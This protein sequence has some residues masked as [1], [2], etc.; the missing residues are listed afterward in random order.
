[1]LIFAY[2]SVAKI[3]VGTIISICSFPKYDISVS[4]ALLLLQLFDEFFSATLT[5]TVGDKPGRQSPPLRPDLPSQLDILTTKLRDMILQVLLRSWSGLSQQGMINDFLTQS[6]TKTQTIG[7][8][9][10][11]TAL[12]P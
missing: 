9:L 12:S 2:S 8:H 4:I 6:D 1:M 11:F 10:P 5:L 7:P 3:Y